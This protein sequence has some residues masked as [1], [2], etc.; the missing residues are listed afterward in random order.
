MI[1][2]IIPASYTGFQPSSFANASLLLPRLRIMISFKN[3]TI[4]KA[5]NLVFLKL[6][7][8]FIV[9]NSPGTRSPN[10]IVVRVINAQ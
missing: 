7:Y 3:V 10:P 4:E 1:Q 2:R 6:S 9:I 8:S 5:N